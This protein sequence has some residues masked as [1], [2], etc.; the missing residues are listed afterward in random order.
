MGF[1]LLQPKKKGKLE[2]VNRSQLLKFVKQH[3]AD[4]GLE[5]FLGRGRFVYLDYNERIACDGYFDDKIGRLALAKDADSDVIV[6]EY[7]HSLQ[8]LYYGRKY[9]EKTSLLDLELDCEQKTVEALKEFKIDVDLN[10]YVKA[11][12]A[13]V[14]GYAFSNNPYKTFRRPPHMVKFIRQQMPDCFLPPEEY[15]NPPQWLI[16][17][18]GGHCY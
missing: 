13:H 10:A 18:I 11:S 7:C 14:Y 5:F 12:N 17:A 1:L 9:F 8:F 3:C 16:D 15:R 4:F 6:H 2:K